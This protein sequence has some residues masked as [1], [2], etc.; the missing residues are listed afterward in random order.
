MKR[1][2]CIC[3]VVL[4]LASSASA[5]EISFGAKGG[6]FVSNITSIPQGWS[7]TAFRNGFSGGVFMNY[8]LDQNFSLQPEVL[9]VMKGMEGAITNPVLS[10]GLSGKYNYIEIPLLA[11]YTVPTESGFNPFFFLGPSIGIN[12]SAD[13]DVDGEDR[14]SG[15]KL[16]GSVD[17]SSV[18]KTMEYGL[19]IGMGFGYGVGP[20]RMTVDARFQ[21]DLVGITKGGTVTGVIS[22]EPYTDTLEEDETKNIGFAAMLGYAF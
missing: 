8:A 18:T 9:Y 12:L 3:L 22:G 21:F 14:M 11:K 1:T 10:L 5:G 15:E 20:G 6:L 19:I 13:I 2:A 7:D 16:V 17:Y 4:V